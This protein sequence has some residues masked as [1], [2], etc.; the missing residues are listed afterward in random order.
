MTETQTPAERLS[1]VLPVNDLA[2][3]VAGWTA[4]LGVEPTFIDGARWAQFDVAGGRLSLAGTDRFAD[5]TGVMVK[6]PD[7]DAVRR[8][9]SALGLTVG[10]VEHGP[11]E[12]RCVVTGPG[13]V[14]VALYSALP[15]PVG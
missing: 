14:P 2:S 1:V 10:E 9:L 5:I 13:G 6:V 15:P 8:T 4:L 7:V 11:H 12:T 3:A